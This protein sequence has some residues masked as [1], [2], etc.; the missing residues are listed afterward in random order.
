MNWRR[1]TAFSRLPSRGNSKS[2]SKQGGRSIIPQYLK[3]KENKE[4]HHKTQYGAQEY[5]KLQL[6]IANRFA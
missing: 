6:L 3:L 2:G 5:R 1:P 4:K